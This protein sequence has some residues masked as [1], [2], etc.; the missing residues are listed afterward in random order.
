MGPISRQDMQAMLESSKNRILERAACKTDL[1][2][3]QDLMKSIM[4]IFQQNQQ[5]MKQFENQLLQVARRD[6]QLE[7]RLATV[8]RDIKELKAEMFRLLDLEPLIIQAYSA[9]GKQR[10]SEVTYVATT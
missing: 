10:Q 4:Q 3:I 2:P 8:E 9:A 7:A 5:L 1:Q 6:I